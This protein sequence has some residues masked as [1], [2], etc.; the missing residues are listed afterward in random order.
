M[1]PTWSESAAFRGA[2][3]N[4]AFV[5]RAWVI[6]VTTWV[7]PRNG[8]AVRGTATLVVTPAAHD[9]TT[10][11]G[12]GPARRARTVPSTRS[13]VGRLPSAATIWW[14][15]QSGS[16]GGVVRCVVTLGR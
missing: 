14:K 8:G 16:G 7:G 4:E 5:R 10:A 3:A 9:A 12:T 2:A 1:C 15:S 11:A 6:G 13:I